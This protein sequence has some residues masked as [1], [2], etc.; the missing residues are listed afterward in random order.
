MEIENTHYILTAAHVWH[1]TKDADQIG[2]ALTLYPSSFW[3]RRDAI[4]SKDLWARGDSQWGPDLSLLKIPSPFVS[5][6]AAHKSFLNLPQQRMSFTTSS[7]ANGK[8]LF[9]VTGMVGEFNPPQPN[10]DA[11]IIEFDI[12]ARAF[13]SLLHQT[14]ER[15]GYDYIDISA[16]DLDGVPKSFRGVSGGGLWRVCLSMSKS[17]KISWDGKRHFQGLAFWESTVSNGL[18][19]LRCHGP[20]SIFERAWKSWTLP[21]TTSR[22]DRFQKET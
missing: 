2:L 9:A 14:H 19:V 1:E 6:I 10:Q 21:E 22:K 11:R 18:R 17:G 5:T 15:N 20:K 16:K 4:L 7:P 13:F 12:Q 8:E 3:I